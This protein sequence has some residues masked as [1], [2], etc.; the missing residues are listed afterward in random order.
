MSKTRYTTDPV[1]LITEIIKQQSCGNLVEQ[2]WIEELRRWWFFRS[3]RYHLRV[4]ENRAI[5]LKLCLEPQSQI[6]ELTMSSLFKPSQKKVLRVTG[7]GADGTSAPIEN[8]SVVASDPS[9]LTV[10]QVEGGF[11]LASTGM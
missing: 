7:L 4:R 9:L 6:G 1:L 2:V 5:A 3:V 11:L 10:T 8:I